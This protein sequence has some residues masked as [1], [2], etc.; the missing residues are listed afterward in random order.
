MALYRRVTY[1]DRC[2]IQAF[3]QQETEISCIV[4]ELGF[5]KST[6]YREISR[7]GMK[8]RYWAQHAQKQAKRRFCRCRRPLIIGHQEHKL[9]LKLL[10]HQWSPQMIT[11]RCRLEGVPFVSHQTVYDHISRH[12][13]ELGPF[14]CRYQRR[15]A[16]RLRQRNSRQKRQ[17][18]GIHQRPLGAKNRTRFGHWERDTMEGK[19]RKK[20]LLLVCTERKSR[21][22]KLTKTSMHIKVNSRV[23]KKLLSAVHKKVLS[24]T[25]DRGAEFRDGPNMEV[26][27]FYCNAQKPQQRGTVENTIGVLRR[28]LSRKTKLNKL[29]ERQLRKIEKQLNLRPMRCL[30]YRTPY[31]VLYRTTV[32]LAS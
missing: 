23:T 25:N 9:I 10:S 31:E 29:S 32:A 5:D 24:I 13:D 26:P 27:V 11:K 22:T 21:F 4:G 20:D 19:G 6:I 14:L 12:W 8:G 28:V 1:E 16:G 7:N 17:Y 30:D 18:R 3:L 15:G 2:Q